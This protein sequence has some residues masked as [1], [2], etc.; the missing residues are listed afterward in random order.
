[1]SLATRPRSVHGLIFAAAAF[2][3]ALA[4]AAADAIPPTASVGAISEVSTVSAVAHG[5]V[6]PGA[7][8]TSYHFEYAT[9][10]LGPGFR[11]NDSFAGEAVPAD[12]GLS[13]VTERLYGSYESSVTPGAL[14]FVA[15]DPGTQYFV[16]LAASNGSG[17]VVTSSPYGVFTTLSVPPP[18]KGGI[19]CFGDACQPLPPEPEDPTTGTLRSKPSGNFPAPTSKPPKSCGKGRVRKHG[20]CVKPHRG[21]RQRK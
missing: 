8:E 21:K 15:L 20:K 3:L 5:L 18:P 12:A 4:P 16:R 13:E 14:Y 2:A 17:S 19:P 6:D 10:T 7:E 9:N 11:G 1:M